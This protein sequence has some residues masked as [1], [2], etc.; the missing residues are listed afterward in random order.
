MATDTVVTGA[1]S[2][3]KTDISMSIFKHLCHGFWSIKVLVYSFNKKNDLNHF[4]KNRWQPLSPCMKSQL[5]PITHQHH[6]SRFLAPGPGPRRCCP[7]AAWHKDKLTARP[8]KGFSESGQNKLGFYKTRLNILLL[9]CHSSDKLCNF[10]AMT[11][12]FSQLYNFSLLQIEIECSDW[13]VTG[14]SSS[15]FFV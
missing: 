4:A 6:F 13:L 10:M 3:S 12:S 9:L 8:L 11:F 1:S 7:P 2:F 5:I 15:F 14:L